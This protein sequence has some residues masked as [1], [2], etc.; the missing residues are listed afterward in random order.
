MEKAHPGGAA[1]V[2]G[3]VQEWEAPGEEEWAA[4]EQAQVRKENALALNAERLSLMKWAFPVIAA[5]VPN[6][7]KRW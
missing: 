1:P 5:N 3:E 4:L 6:V 2:Q 7:G